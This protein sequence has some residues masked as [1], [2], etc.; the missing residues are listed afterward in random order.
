MSYDDIIAGA[1]ELYYPVATYDAKKSFQLLLASEFGKKTTE[2]FQE[3]KCPHYIFN[4]V[5]GGHGKLEVNGETYYPKKG[6]FFFLPKALSH[7]GVTDPKSPWW[8]LYFYF[9]GW[10]AEEMIRA[11]G[12][13]DRYYIP[14][15]PVELLFRR[16]LQVAKE[17]EL[18]V[19]EK[20]ALV[21]HEI[22]AELKKKLTD[23][24]SKYS[25][26]VKK[27]RVYINRNIEKHL[28]M[29]EI[30]DHACLSVEHLTRIFKKEVGVTPYAYL[31]FKRLNLAKVYLRSTALPIKAIA[32]RLNY[33][34][35]FYFSNSFKKH[36][37]MSP[38]QYR[39]DYFKNNS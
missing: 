37:G 13:E 33:S 3:R 34:D 15:C 25:P 10:F 39:S 20:S 21:I 29:E 5:L 16:I 8:K 14:D 18:D 28:T 19:N 26:H 11:Y 4:Y 32:F 23:V 38:N 36:F 1:H 17:K 35:E 22:L 2:R 31:T 7:L 12:L 24:A 30:A 9:D 27:T 6:D